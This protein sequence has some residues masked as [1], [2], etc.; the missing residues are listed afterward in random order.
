MGRSSNLGRLP[1]LLGV[2]GLASLAPMGLAAHANK[3]GVPALY[4][5]R[6]E[7]EEAARKHF[8]CSGAHAM[9]QQWMPCAKHGPSSGSA[10][11]HH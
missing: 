5:T 7:A 8:N 4:A 9:G 6:A 11:N 10:P 2:V 1:S 3:S